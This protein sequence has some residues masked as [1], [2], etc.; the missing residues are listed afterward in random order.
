VR[1]LSRAEAV[2]VQRLLAHIDVADGDG[3]GGERLP[4]RTAQAIRQRAYVRDW[5]TDRY[6]PNPVVLG[7]RTALFL[8]ARPYSERALA[9]MEQWRSHPRNVLLWASPE[10]LFGVF[11]ARGPEE[12]EAIQ[13][14]LTDASA[15]RLEVGLRTDL[16]EATVPVYFDFESAWTGWTGLPGTIR[17]PRPLPSGEFDRPNGGGLSPGERGAISGLL[18]APFLGGNPARGV[19]RFS[20][21]YRAERRWLNS[22]QVEFRSFLNPR[23]VARW[24]TGFADQAVFVH[25]E[26]VEPGGASELFHA[27]VSECRIGPFLFAT[28]GRSVLWGALSSTSFTPPRRSSVPVL[29]KVGTYLRGIQIV[30]EDLAHLEPT[31]DHRF[32]RLLPPSALSTS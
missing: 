8:V 14:R 18:V 22:G 26:L 29:A 5:L 24:V 28:N 30:R 6:V 16:T 27:L 12:A 10:L 19:S 9:I 21:L 31:V 1:V 4:L 17:Y 2:A 23:E 20:R 3:S 32:E 25:G 13:R 7:Y 11:L 15:V